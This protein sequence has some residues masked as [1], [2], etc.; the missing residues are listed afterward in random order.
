MALS[1]VQRS[2][3]AWSSRPPGPQPL[4]SAIGTVL[5]G[6]GRAID[7]LGITLQGD[8][9]YIEKLPVPS[10]AVKVGGLAP[11]VEGAAFIAPS[12]N[13]LGAVSVGEGAS[14]WYAAMLKGDTAPVSVGESSVVSDRAII[15]GSEIGSGV[16]I[17]AG[18]IVTTSKLGDGCAIGMGCNVGAGCTI[19]EGS[20]LAAGAVLSPG[21]SVPPG[22]VWSGAPAKMAAAVSA[23][24]SDVVKENGTLAGKLA[25][26]HAAE[27]WKAA[28][29]IDQEK[30]DY[31]IQKQRTAQYI[32]T[33]REDPKW[34]PMPTL[35]D[36]L[37]KSSAYELPSTPK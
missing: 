2:T 6:A 10:T 31:K 24:D 14:V 36:F 12:A 13:L 37:E 3:L 5:R 32:S 22:Q 23:A 29:A 25:A 28:E 4:W 16:L 30:G 18:A 26:V 15:S 17:G 27:A 7:A 20:V 35:G 19:G 9:A 1:S 34:V 8:C 11:S 33:L 21:T